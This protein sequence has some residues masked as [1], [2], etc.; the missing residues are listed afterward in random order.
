ME[1]RGQEAGRA[2]EGCVG[3]V[4]AADLARVAAT[5]ATLRAALEAN[6]EGRPG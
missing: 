1:V 3:L 5:L 2:G 4:P 6:A